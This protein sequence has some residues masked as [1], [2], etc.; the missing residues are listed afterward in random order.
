MMKLPL[1]RGDCK[2]RHRRFMYKCAKCSKVYSDD[3]VPPNDGCGG[4]IDITPDLE[5]LKETITQEELSS[6][7]P[8]HWKY[9]ELLP[10]RKKE[11][12]ITLGEGGT[13]LIKA[14]RLGKKYGL[15]NL[16][17]KI[18]TMN[19]SGSFKDRPISVGLSRAI[20]DGASVVI[21]ASSG[22]AAASLATY[23]ARS[24][25]KTI[26][27][28]PEKVP[29]GKL[30]HLLVLGTKV[31][32]V[33]PT[34]PNV[35]PTT[36]LLQEAYTE[37]DWTPIPSFG[38]FNCFQYEGNKTIGYELAE[39]FEWKTP[40]W[41]FF[42]TGSGGLMSGTMKGIYEFKEL[43]LI[44]EI[45]KP[46][47]VQPTGCSPLVEAFQKSKK[48]TEIEPA[49]NVDTCAGGLAD[50]FP[51]DGDAALTYLEDAKGMA[52]SVSDYSIKKCLVELGKYEG[53]FGEPSGVAGLAGLKQMI[54]DGTIDKQDQI[55]VPITGSGFKDLH[56]IKA[57]IPKTPVIS[58]SLE[59]LLEAVR[60]YD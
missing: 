36:A 45:P 59:K 58:Q 14:D 47:V 32:Q 24:G 35:D 28:V 15:D 21:S 18:E 54:E 60:E 16:F 51:W 12:I 46:V 9:F 6:R 53:I 43:G 1:G 17:L 11:S 13:P 34:V 30:I 8:A 41:V 38:P 3:D 31:I 39:Q 25:T 44:E 22:N 48:P 49:E 37:L 20:E 52:I 40:D 26:V 56:L 2:M 27:L 55:I 33:K 5:L 50:P 29:S 7:N 10:I 4:R 19:P 57:L 23:S 42:P